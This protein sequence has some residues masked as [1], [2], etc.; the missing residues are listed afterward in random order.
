MIEQHP[1]QA[2]ARHPN[3]ELAG[4][5][6]RRCRQRAQGRPL[7]F[8]AHRASE[9]ALPYQLSQKA[10]VGAAV[11]KVAAA[12]HPQRLIDGLLEAEVRLFDIAVLM[13]QT[14]GVGRRLHAVVG[15]QRPVVLGKFM[16][17]VA[18]EVT[19]RGGE[20]VGAVPFRHATDLPQT[21]LQP[22]GQ[23]LEALREAHSR[24]LDIR[25]GQHQVIDQMRKRRA[26]ET[27]TERVHG[28][29]VGLRHAPRQVL[30]RKHDLLP[31]SV[32]NPPRLHMP[33]QR[34]QLPFLVTTWER[35]A[36]QREQ[37]LRLQR[38]IVADLGLDPRP[39]LRRRDRPASDA[40]AAC[41]I[42]LGNFP[43]CSYL[44]A[45]RSLTPARAAANF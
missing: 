29:E 4:E 7:G 20:V 30:L 11:G 32:A 1:D 25:V 39:V 8:K 15:Q 10:L 9:I 13:R 27:H 5:V 6:Q 35:G 44:R 43:A 18:V 12:T 3:R 42:W 23:R 36:Q 45:V 16:P 33:L 26:G 17:P 40:Y 28:R 41:F 31:R 14:G 38:R 24:R 21:V 19:H 34:A 37:R 22:L 2:E